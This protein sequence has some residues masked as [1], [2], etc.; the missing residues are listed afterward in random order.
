MN[1]WQIL[2]PSDG[3][4]TVAVELLLK[5]SLIVALAGLI[6]ARLRRHSAALRHLV[7]CAALAN[8]ALLPVAK[9]L[10]PA[11]DI[12]L[13]VHMPPAATDRDTSHE[14]DQTVDSSLVAGPVS[15]LWPA[16]L[17][18]HALLTESSSASVQRAYLPT[19]PVM[20]VNGI[21][22]VGFMVALT[23]LACAAACL[24]RLRRTAKPIYDGEAFELLREL[25]SRMGLRRT[26]ALLQTRGNWVP[27]TWGVFRPVVL[28][29]EEA[30]TWAAERLRVVLM[31]ELSHVRRHD[32]LTQFA[33]HLVRACYW[34][35]P[36]VWWAVRRLKTEQ[37]RAC[38]DAVVH[39]GST[40]P[41]YAQHLLSVLAQV[42]DS[43]FVSPV[44]LAM[45][46]ARRLESRLTGILDPACDRRP[47]SR[48][49]SLLV[50]AAA[51]ALVMPLAS[52]QVRL[53]AA[54]SDEPSTNAQAPDKKPTGQPLS[55][56]E[57]R[58][59]VM[60]AY[61]GNFDEKALDAGA[62]RGMVEA[63]RDPYAAYLD[64]SQLQEA[65]R[66][67]SGTVAGIGVQLSSKDGRF[68]VVTPLEGSPALEAGIKAGDVIEA[69]DGKPVQ[70]LEMPSVVQM[71]LGKPGTMV[72]IKIRRSD[73]TQIEPELTRKQLRLATVQGFRRDGEG[74]WEYALD[75]ARK[76]GYARLTQF[77][78]N[79]V[80]ELRDVVEALK[81]QDL[82]GFILDLRGCPGG[83]LNAAVQVANVFIADGLI[84]SIKG[85]AGE[86]KH[87]ADPANALGEFPLIVLIDAHT[88]S[89]AEIVAGA[90]KDRERAVLLG[91]RTFGKGSVQTI[92]DLPP[93]QGAL[94]LTTA[95]Y[96]LPGGRNLQ[97]K[98]DAKEWGVDPTDGYYVP[99]TSK[100]TESLQANQREREKL[101]V[102]RPK[103]GSEVTP[104]SIEEDFADRQLAAAL[105]S[106]LA[107][108]EKG[109]FVKVGGS[110][111]T[112][113]SQ[114]MQ[115]ER[116][117]KI[118]DSLRKNLE[119]I[120]KELAELEKAADRR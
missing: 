110:S 68:V 43:Y 1:A 103:Q 77:G 107:R 22:F 116:L 42:P 113:Q 60:K 79:T 119:D 80:K 95:H 33:A 50:C 81:K 88:A 111:A 49:R 31:H 102:P 115:R 25:H 90:L 9:V 97:K 53:H 47:P 3:P 19:G 120:N 58:E 57:I 72:K 64:P 94:K 37:E 93:E 85:H 32:C 55:L 11:W 2:A 67:M 10:V 76:I 74:R 45:G 26:I 108:L 51:L 40:G 41:D 101:G 23:P 6:A 12:S 112:L 17:K 28:L 16:N 21:W 34:F 62:I 99:L 15:G 105:K 59:A 109:E 104:Q 91:E 18:S 48:L 46:R 8:L 56:S 27:M 106:M 114:L 87:N 86:N 66:Q 71:I 84:V 78:A 96:Y 70:G 65:Q 63:L 14:L 35:H 75:P 38:D 89:A 54:T 117:E 29:P 4:T 83:F 39:A 13:P 100:Q 118:R 52:V 69:V 92:V 61:G 82:K 30:M 36:L 98:P 73:G 44:A 24:W 20:P 7:W 5:G